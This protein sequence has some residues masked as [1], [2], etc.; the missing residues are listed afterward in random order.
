MEC[1]PSDPELLAQRWVEELDRNSVGRAALIASLPGDEDS[2]TRA[3]SRFRERFFGY[4]MANPLAPEAG[5]RVGR[6]FASG[7]QGLALFPAMH[8]YSIMD[9][10]A[11]KLLEIASAAAGRLVLVHCGVLSVGIRGKLGLPSRFD[12][13]YSNPI[14]LHAVALQ[15]PRLPFVVPHFGAGY[16]RETLM[17]ADLCAN[18][19]LDTSSSN[20]WTRYEPED[21]DLT[22]VF[23]RALA[24]AGP[25]RI[26]FGTDSSFFPRGWQ[27]AIFDSQ[28]HAMQA[29]G[30]SEAAAASI[31]GGNLR[32]LLAGAGY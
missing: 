12:M 19:Y 23:R 31:L 22:T 20:R 11:V 1:P 30:V 10:R 8:G 6:A 27:R 17:L 16:F 21:L 29:A 4:F 7:L 25:E 32:R 5:E 9:P 18:V 15:F 28:T 2:V 24:V 14:D 3:V 26:L 13:R